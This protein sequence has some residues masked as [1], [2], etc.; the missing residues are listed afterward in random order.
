MTEL[1][2]AS[3]SRQTKETKIDLSLNLDGIGKAD[4]RTGE[5]FFDHMLDQLAKHSG[6]DISLRCEGDLEID[7]HH[8][9]EDSGIVLGQAIRQALGDKLGIRRYGFA[10]VPMD[11]ALAQVSIDLSGRPFLHFQAAVPAE[12]LGTFE[13]ETVQEFM[14]ALAQ[15]A[16]MT[17]HINVPY[18]E[19]S[20]H[21]I[22]GIFKALAVALAEAIAIDPRR[23]G[24]LPSTKGS[25]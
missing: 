25:L 14:R 3:L 10:S 11:E 13:T 5:A 17:L 20:H 18:G 6:M 4:N 2:K 1:R 24:V 16:Q 7:C 9:V 22:E 8:T 23:A 21:I 15:N 19:N 12:Q